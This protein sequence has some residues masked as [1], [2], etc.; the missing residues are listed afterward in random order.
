MKG[1][2]AAGARQWGDASGEMDEAGWERGVGCSGWRRTHLAVLVERV[3][4][5]GACVLE[6]DSQRATQREEEDKVVEHRVLEQIV[7]AAK[8]T[9]PDWEVQ[10]K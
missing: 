4:T 5:R 1:T 2:W 9:L 6:G 8:L 3:P 10:S 7:G